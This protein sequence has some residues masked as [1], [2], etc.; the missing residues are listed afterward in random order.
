[1]Y[2]NNTLKI[3]QQIESLGIN[4]TFPMFYEEFQS[5]GLKNWNIS[6][7]VDSG[8][9][10]YELYEFDNALQF[11]VSISRNWNVIFT[12]VAI[13]VGIV[14]LA[15]FFLGKRF[16]KRRRRRKTRFDVILSDIEV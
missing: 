10:I 7:F 4:E 1:M 8:S 9:Q 6:I 16:R 12:G 14:V 3:N 11:F 15:L 2:V 5:F 13:L